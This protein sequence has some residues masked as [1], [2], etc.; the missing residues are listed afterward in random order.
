LQHQFNGEEIIMAR[1]SLIRWQPTATQLK[2]SVNE[3]TPA[4][5]PQCIKSIL[6]SLGLL[7]LTACQAA[8]WRGPLSISAGALA[9]EYEE[10]NASARAKYDGKEIVV[11]GFAATAAKMPQAGI[12]QG[13]VSLKEKASDS[14]LEV[15]CWFSRDQTQ[16]FSRIK[17][18][19]YI[20]VK[21]V[22]NGEAG[23]ELKFC[24]LIKTE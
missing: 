18:G 14:A 1:V 16:E 9:T 23:A 24:K 21:G 11:R 13:S 17:S 4:A 22:F 6:V 10:S 5:R 7:M 3:R 2:Q 15:T 8:S 19:E 12:D 20:T